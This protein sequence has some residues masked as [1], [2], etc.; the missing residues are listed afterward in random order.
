M[1]VWLIPC[2]SFLLFDGGFF[3][4]LGP[5][6]SVGPADVR[7][8]KRGWEEGR[9]IRLERDAKGIMTYST[10]SKDIE[11]SWENGI[12]ARGCGESG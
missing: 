11:R 8:W 3:P 7:H 5:K 2:F 1:Y 9:R 4:G 10:T 6:K 12:V